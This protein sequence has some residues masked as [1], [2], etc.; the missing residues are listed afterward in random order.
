[1]DEEDS[2]GDSSSFASEGIVNEDVASPVSAEDASVPVSTEHFADEDDDRSQTPLQDEV[3]A[4]D[5]QVTGLTGNVQEVTISPT[6]QQESKQDTTGVDTSTR[7]VDNDDEVFK[8]TMRDDHGELDYDEEVQPDACP[9]VVTDEGG[10]HMHQKA[11]DEEEKEDGEERVDIYICSLRSS[12][13]DLP[14]GT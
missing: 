7:H 14:S 5:E 6:Q 13:K 10:S 2:G 1:M 4:A 9:V 8:Q 3:I 11:A 12:L